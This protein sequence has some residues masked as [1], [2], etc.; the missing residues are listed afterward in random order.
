MADDNGMQ[1][2][3]SGDGR[4]PGEP[5]GNALTWF[6]P[7]AVKGDFSAATIDGYFRHVQNWL[8]SDMAFLREPIH[9]WHRRSNR[10][11][12][13]GFAAV[14]AGVLLP[15]PILDPWPGWPD[16]LQM[17]Y[18]AVLI[19]GLVLLLDRVFNVSN[20]WM[21]LTLAEMQLKQVRYRLDLDWAKRRPLLTTEN[22]A[23]EGPALM[24]ILRTAMDAGHQIMET[25]KT[26]WTTELTQAMDALRSRLDA[27]RTS[28]EQV[29]AERA[30]ERA[31]PATGGVTI[32]IDKPELLKPPLKIRAGLLPEERVDP[33]PPIWAMVGLP[34]GSARVIV[35]AERVAP[36]GSTYK[37]ARPVQVV[38]GEVQETAFNV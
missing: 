20:S 36:A 8:E 30:R 37:A 10:T 1:D 32:K 15:M 25:Q 23:T 24:E 33:V 12:G 38:A 34:P 4:P 26:T 21:R 31:R 11:R 2:E 22:A 18:L 16:G 7:L 3:A 5:G 27:D 6:E 14:A 29:R 28:L 17:G 35:E 13:L 9:R 19:G